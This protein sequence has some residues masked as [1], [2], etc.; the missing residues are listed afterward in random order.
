MLRRLRFS[1]SYECAKKALATAIV[2]LDEMQRDPD[3]FQ[4][5][6]ILALSV[7]RALNFH[8]GTNYLPQLIQ[9][10]DQAPTFDVYGFCRLPRYFLHPYTSQSLDEYKI[11]DALEAV[12]CDNWNV[13]LLDA[14]GKYRLDPIVRQLA[15]KQLTAFLEK[16]GEEDQ[17][18][19]SEEEVKTALENCFRQVLKADPEEGFN[20]DVIQLEELRVPLKN[21][22]W[23]QAMIC[24]TFVL[25][26]VACLPDFLQGWGFVNLAF[27]ANQIGRFPLLN[28]IP[29]QILGEWIWKGMCFGNFLKF[30][31]A[32][33]AL[34]KGRLTLEGQKEG[35]WLTAA[36]L[37]EC[38]YCL[39]IVQKQDLRL[40]N[41][42]ALIAKS[43]GILAFLA[44]SRLTFF[45]DG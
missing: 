40:I 32:A 11:L 20:P 2:L 43:L 8:C 25:V 45:N 33:H 13:G 31:D 18:F 36:S 29:R 6:C 14:Q 15:Q 23:L 44:R 9:V 35:K 39:S 7:I 34:W 10:L 12:L 1:F 22:S 16:M 28:W 17:D 37:A 27:Y 41:G 3:L 21:N 30:V 26:D 4:K 42:L 38:V 24:T 5:V 19:G